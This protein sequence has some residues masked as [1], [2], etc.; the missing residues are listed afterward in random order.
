MKEA[1]EFQIWNTRGDFL[2]SRRTEAMI[3]AIMAEKELCLQDITSFQEL[4]DSI[5]ARKRKTGARV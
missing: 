5:K 1:I 3:R 2:E 4:R